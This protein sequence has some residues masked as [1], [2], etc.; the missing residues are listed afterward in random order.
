M[1]IMNRWAEDD[2]V[3]TLTAQ[4]MED[5]GAQVISITY[6]GSA[7]YDHAMAPHSR[8]IVFA[9]ATDSAHVDRIDK[10]ISKKLEKLG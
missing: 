3:A 2:M 4:A 6:N 5:E 8:Y 10:A 9:R 1:I 7:K